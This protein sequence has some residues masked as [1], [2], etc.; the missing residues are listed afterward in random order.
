MIMYII[1]IVI[2][3]VYARARI[4]HTAPLGK[5]DEEINAVIKILPSSLNNTEDRFDIIEKLK[6]LE[7][8][9][10]VIVL[11][12]L[13]DQESGKDTL[14][15]K[16]NPHKTLSI[17]SRRKT[18]ELVPG[19]LTALGILGTF[20][21]LAIS[22]PALSNASG[23]DITIGVQRIADGL[24]TAFVTSIAGIAASLLWNRK[25]KKLWEKSNDSLYD[26]IEK[27]DSL[28]AIENPIN[29]LVKIEDYQNQQTEILKSIVT[30]FAAEMQNVLVPG[31]KE[32]ISS[33][34]APSLDRMENVIEGF[35]S[36]ASENQFDGV[37][38]IVES[39]VSSMNGALQGQFEEL[40]KTI[41]ELCEWQRETKDELN[42]LIEGIK[43]SSISQNNINNRTSEI[44]D[45]MSNYHN[46]LNASTENMVKQQVEL[47]E[48]TKE[49]NTTSSNTHILFDKVME[50]SDYIDQSN[51]AHMD[52]MQD[53]I[54]NMESVWGESQK[55]L[56]EAKQNF[57]DS[58]KMFGE[59]MHSGLVKS[60]TEFDKNITEFS[61]HFQNNMDDMKTASESIG[62]LIVESSESM[63]KTVN[64]LDKV[65]G[66]LPKSI[67]VNV[68]K[69]V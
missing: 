9:I 59:N 17:P 23:S 13:K 19:V 28:L 58:S 44:I 33:G 47:H 38:Q 26:L 6:N 14:E 16:L 66:D 69:S 8:N 40:G 32:G 53:N 41:Q 63:D 7:T 48:L 11:D 27:L 24:S 34:M 22:L 30:D 45:N 35:G 42:I 55:I 5:I 18:A 67:K 52:Q 15:L 46:S 1:L 2:A 29:K 12:I 62:R 31:I 21:G 25:D 68:E 60:F 20:I 37:S 4:K 43:E 64:H 3:V 56:D 57:D 10:S 61:R 51:K 36:S 49:L 50:R 54:A 39:F 65:L